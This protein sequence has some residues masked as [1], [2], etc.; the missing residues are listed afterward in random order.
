[1][2][3][4]SRFAAALLLLI[5]GVVSAHAQ[6]PTPTPPVNI[7]LDSDMADDE[8]EQVIAAVSAVHWSMTGA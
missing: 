5:S 4:L 8:I 2:K 7:I 6:F 1:M 3:V